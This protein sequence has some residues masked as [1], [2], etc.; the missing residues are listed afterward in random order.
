MYLCLYKKYSNCFKITKSKS[1][2]KTES[3]NKN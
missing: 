3:K 2:S 1:K